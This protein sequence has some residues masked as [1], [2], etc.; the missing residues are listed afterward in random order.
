MES[1]NGAKA[2]TAD[3][4]I[5][6]SGTPR[7]D[8]SA[9]TSRRC[10]LATASAAGEEVVLNFGAKVGRQDAAGDVR[11]E[12]LQRIALRP[13]T[14]K[15]LKALLNRAISEYDQPRRRS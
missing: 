6:Q 12:L 1:S 11:A 10:A 3:V 14:A 7:W 5:S 9:V 15:N 8:N 13:L 2:P 4:P